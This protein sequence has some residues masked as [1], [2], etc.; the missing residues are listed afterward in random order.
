[1]AKHMSSH[2]ICVSLGVCG[3][4]ALV[5]VRVSGRTTDYTTPNGRSEDSASICLSDNGIETL[6]LLKNPFPDF[7]FTRALQILKNYMYAFAWL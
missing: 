5:C 7:L 2:T 4:G 3:R 1:M 6:V